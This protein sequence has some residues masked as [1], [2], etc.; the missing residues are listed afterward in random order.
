MSVSFLAA[1]ALAAGTT[2]ASPTPEP[3]PMVRIAELEIDPAQLETYK[4][5]LAEEQAASVRLEPGVLML[6]SVALVERPTSVR[7]L[8]VYASRA[9]YEAHIRSPHFLRYKS[10]TERMVRSLRLVETQPILLCAKSKGAAGGAVT[11]L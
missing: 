7:L 2:G 10:A 11:C 3:A 1:A 4:R 8:E 9:A 5:L 6:H